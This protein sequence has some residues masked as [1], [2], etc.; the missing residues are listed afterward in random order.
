MKIV[1][2]L[3]GALL[4]CTVASARPLILEPTSFF[5]DPAE[6]IGLTGNEA[7]L[8]N[9]IYEDQP[10]PDLPQEVTQ[11]VKLYKRGS[12][13]QWT[14]VRDIFSERSAYNQNEGYYLEVQG[15]VAAV[16]LPSGLH[17]FER[18]STGW[19]E[20]SLDIPRPQSSVVAVDSGRVLAIETEAGVC[21]PEAVLLER[22][23]NGHWNI[24]ARLPAPAGACVSSFALDTNA[25][26]LLSRPASQTQGINSTALRIFE[27]SGSAWIQAAQ[28]AGAE[29]GTQLYGP[30]LDIHSGLALVSGT[31]KGM[32]VY[33]RGGSAWTEGDPLKFPDAYDNAGHFARAIEITDAY[34]LADG[35]NTN[36]RTDAVYLFRNEP[37]NAFPHLALLTA[38]SSNGF[39][40][41]V[42]D[43]NRVLANGFGYPGTFELP[44]NFT[45]PPVV[46]DD[47]EAGPGAWQI[48]PGSQFSVV[49]KGSTHVWRQ[50]S[51]AGN[52]GAVLD[53]DRTNQ[54]VSA[55][56]TATAVNGND[57][58][59][60]LVTRYT[61][62][63]NYYYVTIRGLTDDSERIVLKRMQNGRMDRPGDVFG[64]HRH[65]AQPAHPADARVHGGLSHR[66]PR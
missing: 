63:S 38:A 60:G 26:A 58:W 29:S 15:S 14:Y 10:D 19:V 4:A 66:V 30:V 6:F 1:P 40:D 34:V 62:E 25:A 44:A 65:R 56:I 32:H 3:C 61:D 13:G 39:Y 31:E 37:A 18:T 48:L 11:V 28:F 35:Y 47:F 41:A 64:G 22:G 55:E 20:A 46:Q 42:I 59:V 45:P 54:S 16:V 51:L 57:R 53:V 50:S 24:S 27:R 21:A 2:V 52:A 33:R 36:R 5:P 23:T 9:S 8:T 7:L 12:N 49:Q 17:I 43:G